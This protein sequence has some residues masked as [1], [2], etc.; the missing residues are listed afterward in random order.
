MGI[1]KYFKEQSFYDKIVILMFLHIIGRLF[2]TINKLGG[3]VICVYAVLMI[4]KITYQNR[5]KIHFPV[6]GF[7]RTLLKL[8]FFLSLVAVILQGYFRGEAIWYGEIPTMMSFH[9]VVDNFYLAVLLPLLILFDYRHFSFKAILKFSPIISVI[10]L[11]FIIINYRLLMSISYGDNTGDTTTLF[12]A[13]NIC[14]Y[15][16]NVSFPILLYPFIKRHSRLYPS[17]L[18]GVLAL[19]FCILFARRGSSLSILLIFI[20]ALYVS[21]KTFKTRKKILLIFLIGIGCITLYQ[22]YSN[23]NNSHTFSKIKEKGTTDSRSYVDQMFYKDIFNSLDWIWGRGINGTYY[24]PMTYSSPDGPVF[25]KTRHAQETGFNFL[26]LRGGLFY[27]LIHV[28]FLGGAVFKGLFSSKNNITKLFAL[29]ILISLFE[30]YPHGIPTFSIKFLIIWIGACICYNPTFR[31]M[32]NYSICK[33]LN[34]K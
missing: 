30:L 1:F 17:I 8:Y 19:F 11:F 9:F 4:I 14:N 10:I 32:N 23:P 18:V 21:Y 27:A 3:S 31:G 26:I 13:E 34:I 12:E 24:C 33:Q 16:Y 7:K 29:Y 20:L 5:N 28:I 22:F 15:F 25:S 6:Q 2:L